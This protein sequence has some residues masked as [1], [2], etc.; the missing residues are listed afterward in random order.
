MH[1][2]VIISLYWPAV[3]GELSEIATEVNNVVRVLQ[4]NSR[5]AVGVRLLQGEPEL[6][7]Q[8]G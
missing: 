4:K 1:V 6:E 8:L 5:N 2:S 3:S 7:S